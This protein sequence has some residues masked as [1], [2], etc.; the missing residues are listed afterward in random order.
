M[1]TELPGIRADVTD[2]TIA[3]PVTATLLVAGPS[4]HHSATSSG[5]VRA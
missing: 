2:W 4:E 1:G 5:Q 3:V